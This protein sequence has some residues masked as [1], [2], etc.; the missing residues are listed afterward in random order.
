M[1]KD[2]MEIGEL[3]KESAMERIKAN[4]AQGILGR[5]MLEKAENTKHY[6]KTK[7]YL[8]L[9]LADMA[10][11]RSDKYVYIKNKIA[12]INKHIRMV[13]EEQKQLCANEE[14]RLKL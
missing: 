14:R 10:K 12:N 1:T 11:G 13:E 7:E 5:E 9:T 6:D 3:D 2:T 4:L 8:D